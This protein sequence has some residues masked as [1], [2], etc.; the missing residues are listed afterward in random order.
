[1]ALEVQLS[2]LVRQLNVPIFGE[3][4]RRLHAC[5]CALICFQIALGCLTHPEQVPCTAG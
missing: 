5:R 4:R 2:I 1:M 3:R